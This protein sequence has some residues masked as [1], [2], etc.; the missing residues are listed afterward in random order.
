MVKHQ[1]YDP[2]PQK[3]HPCPFGVCNTKPTKLGLLSLEGEKILKYFVYCKVCGGCGPERDNEVE[4]VQAWNSRA[5]D[6]PSKPSKPGI[7]ARLLGF[8]LLFILTEGRM[9]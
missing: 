6:T 9:K 3:A 7:V 2:E 5:N 4:A 8:F 1:Q